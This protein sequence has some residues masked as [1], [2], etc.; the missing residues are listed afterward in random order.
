LAEGSRRWREI[1]K[2]KAVRKEAAFLA[3]FIQ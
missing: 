2:E 3:V 1:R